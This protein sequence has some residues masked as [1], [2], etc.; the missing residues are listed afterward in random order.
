MGLA[1]LASTRDWAIMLVLVVCILG[2]AEA[3]ALWSFMDKDLLQSMLIGAC[4]G[5]LPSVL[6]CVPVY[7]VVDDL[8]RD[9]L[10]SFLKSVKFTR[11][12]EKNG[13]QFYTQDTPAWMRW[14]SNRVT[15]DP[16]PGGQLSVA[17]PLYCYRILK[18][19]R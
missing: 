10:H 11:H 4:I 8:S 9:A 12:V 6:M 3:V 19:R 14:D 16:L 13:T 18:R 2:M 7:G 17:M 5:M 15:I 1:V